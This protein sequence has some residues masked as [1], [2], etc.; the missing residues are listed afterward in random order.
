MKLLIV[1]IYYPSFMELFYKTNSEAN[2]LNYTEHW[3]VIMN[4]CFG[5]A[6]F[7]SANLKQ[8][9]CEAQE[10]IA[11]NEILQRRWAA[12]NGFKLKFE[13]L[14]SLH[15]YRNK[16]GLRLDLRRKTRWLLEIL[17]QQIIAFSP[18][19]LYVQGINSLPADFVQDMKKHVR[20][21]VCQHASP[22]PQDNK[23]NGYDLILSS[24]PN[25]VAYFRKQGLA[26]EYFRLGFESR[27]LPKLG[28]SDSRYDIVH[29][30]GYGPIHQE[31]NALLEA[32]SRR[33]RIDCWGYNIANVPVDSPLHRYFHGEA[34]GLEMYTIRQNSCIS[35][36]KHIT[37]V[38]DGFANNCTLY[39]ATGTGTL[40]ITDDKENL[41]KLFEPG[42][43][44]VTYKSPEECA[45][46]AKHYLEH[47][48]ERLAIARAGQKR[49][50][51][52]HTY[53]HRMQ[54][55]IEILTRYL[56]RP[57][58]GTRQIFSLGDN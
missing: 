16:K 24:L 38:A 6:D 33:L 45:E 11:N 26:S 39:E 10:I 51:R 21:V 5:T 29:I 36:N 37:S 54:E 43:E 27:I 46:L 18:D 17:R 40:L 25:Q 58:T 52:E 23:L 1:D 50:L 12:E 55:L 2:S 22:L 13:F 32:V 35:I 20:L 41:S 48:D 53:Y 47:Q 4:Q 15:I 30:G 28:K 44:V 8:L 42:R 3:Q 14:P 56:H 57:E 34:W 31:R 9:G 7:Y 49:T 19:I